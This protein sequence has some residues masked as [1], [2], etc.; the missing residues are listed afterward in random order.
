MFELSQNFH[1][2]QYWKAVSLNIEALQV[3]EAGQT[4]RQVHHPIVAQVQDLQ[5]CKCIYSCWQCVQLTR[6]EIEYLHS[7]QCHWDYMN[8]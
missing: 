5:G 4:V 1:L 8:A 7:M 3:K 2:R 6:I